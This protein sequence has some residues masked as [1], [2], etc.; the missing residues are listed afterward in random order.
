MADT[1]D[2]GITKL[3]KVWQELET[4]VIRDHSVPFFKATLLYKV[5]LFS[6]DARLRKIESASK[7]GKKP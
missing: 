4:L 7:G 5:A 6:E 1:Q 2:T 3:T